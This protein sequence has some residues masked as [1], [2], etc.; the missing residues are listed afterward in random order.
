MGAH[1]DRQRLHIYC[2]DSACKNESPGKAHQSGRALV[3]V[4]EKNKARE[5][6][7]AHHVDNL[8]VPK[9]RLIVAPQEAGRRDQGRRGTRLESV[10]NAGEEQQAAAGHRHGPH[11]EEHPEGRLQPS[12]LRVGD[13]P[14]GAAHTRVGHK[15]GL[16]LVQNVIIAKGF[17]LRAWGR[18]G[19]RPCFRTRKRRPCGTANLTMDNR[20]LE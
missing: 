6:G 10:T 14:I 1:R 20:T 11:D 3:C 13:V 4:D 8:P 17:T 18:E 12:M 16:L 15:E 5:E 7:L 9:I 2:K 19:Q